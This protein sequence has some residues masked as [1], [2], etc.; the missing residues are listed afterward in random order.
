VAER[1]VAVKDQ[2]LTVIDH[3]TG[4]QFMLHDDAAQLVR[5]VCAAAAELTTA[6][7]YTLWFH[8]NEGEIKPKLEKGA[9]A[10]KRRP[11][12]GAEAPPAFAERR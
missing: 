1:P 9:K 5:Y 3:A 12:R 6:Q 11:D 7:F 4:E 2:R 8:A 10:M